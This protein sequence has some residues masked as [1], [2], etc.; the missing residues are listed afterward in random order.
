MNYYPFHIGDYASAT[1]H[2]TWEE[3]AAYRRLLD[4]YYTTER[5]LPLEM[6]QIYRLAC[7]ATDSHR[8]AIDVVLSEF[9][10]L[11]E[12]G[13]VHERCESEISAM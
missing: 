7:A 10:L 13:Y 9:F 1:R 4:I 11:A 5:P 12:E 8:V 6:R 2:L 3:D